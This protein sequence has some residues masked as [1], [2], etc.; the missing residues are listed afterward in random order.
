M[1]AAAAASTH[2]VSTDRGVRLEY[3]PSAPGDPAATVAMSSKAGTTG[4]STSRAYSSARWRTR[5][6]EA[7]ADC[8]P[9]MPSA[10]VEGCP[11]RATI[12]RPGN[13]RN[14]P[15]GRKGARRAVR[16]RWAKC[17]PRGPTPSTTASGTER[18]SVTSRGAVRGS[19]AW[20]AAVRAPQAARSGPRTAGTRSPGAVATRAWPVGGSGGRPATSGAADPGPADAGTSTT[21]RSPASGGAVAVETRST[22]LVPSRSSSAASPGPATRR[23]RCRSVATRR[24]VATS[25]S[26]AELTTTAVLRASSAREAVTVGSSPA[27]RAPARASSWSTTSCRCGV[28]VGV[29]AP[30]EAAGPS[31]RRPE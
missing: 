2:G 31:S 9:S 12:R 19:T 24:A 22:V 4:S 7:L 21:S 6:T 1:S 25:A 20:R 15:P 29:A 10:R 11:Y 23:G 18:S 27:P 17:S 28:G 16:T 30:G 13:G 26:V 8:S 3:V 5:A 14:P